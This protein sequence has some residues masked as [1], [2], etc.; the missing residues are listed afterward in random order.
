MSPNFIVAPKFIV[1]IDGPAAAGKGTVARGVAR[2][3]GIFCL[4]TGAMYRA[5][6]LCAL[7]SN[8][9]IEE[10]D[11]LSALLSES[12]I[13]FNAEYAIFLN[14]EDISSEIRKPEMAQ[15][16]SDIAEIPIVREQMKSRQ[17][18]IASEHG[19]IVAEGRDMGT[20][21]FSD[22]K[23]KFYLNASI[24]E[25]ARRRWRELVEHGN[26]IEL[27]EVK[28]LMAMRDEQDSTRDLSPLHPA[29]DAVIINTTALP[30][31]DVVQTIVKAVTG[32]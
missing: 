31:S 30:A 28:N 7:R 4:D 19:A 5:A 15:Y 21:V 3:L 27:E 2:E 32:I 26:Q 1:T 29:P 13:T 22:A 12:K 10:T 23:F 8:T 25:R 18:E 17:R 9:D 16:A 14:G 24:D 20:I 6:A 11:K